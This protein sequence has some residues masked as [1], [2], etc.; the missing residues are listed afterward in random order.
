MPEVAHAGED[1]RDIGGV[2]GGYDLGVADGTA[3]LDDGGRAGGHGRFEA[4][5]KGEERI[6]GDDAAAG[7]RLGEAGGLR[8]V[9]RLQQA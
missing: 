5:G 2:G 3:G 8:R 1:H 6:R 4:V 7:Q 9:R